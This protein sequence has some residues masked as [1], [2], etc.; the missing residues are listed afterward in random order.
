[1]TQNG[2][3]ILFPISKFATQ[4][5]VVKKRKKLSVT[6]EFPIDE[7]SSKGGS[8]MEL[9]SLN[10]TKESE[11]PFIPMLAIFGNKERLFSEVEDGRP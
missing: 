2:D 4:F 1:M 5:K 10:V 8:V 9:A 7:V 3:S 11:L 6:L